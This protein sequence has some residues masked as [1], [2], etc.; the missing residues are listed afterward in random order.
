MRKRRAKQCVGKGTQIIVPVGVKYDLKGFWRG[1]RWL[2]K[3]YWSDVDDEGCFIGYCLFFLL[4]L[5]V[6]KLV[7]GVGW[8][9]DWSWDWDS[10]NSFYLLFFGGVSQLS[11]LKLVEVSLSLSLSLSPQAVLSVHDVFFFFFLCLTGDDSVNAGG[12][13]VTAAVALAVVAPAAAAAASV[14]VAVVVVA[15]FLGGLGFLSLQITWVHPSFVSGW[16][17]GFRPELLSEVVESCCCCWCVFGCILWVGS[18][19]MA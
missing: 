8:A 14:V 5:R 4:D 6:T 9:C 16:S 18:C 13:D 1:R 7:V 19:K 15:L 12:L 3:G 10:L 11:I 17:P 2:E